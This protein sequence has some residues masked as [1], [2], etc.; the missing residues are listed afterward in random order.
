MGSTLS[1]CFY[2]TVPQGH[3]KSTPNPS[4]PLSNLS[5]FHRNG[6]SSGQLLQPLRILAHDPFLRPCRHLILTLGAVV[7]L[8]GWWRRAQDSCTGGKGAIPMQ[9]CT[10]GWYPLSKPKDSEQSTLL[11]ISPQHILKY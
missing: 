2:V 4:P 1:A 9:N 5:G 11:H 8:W 7:R 10:E 3:S 6:P